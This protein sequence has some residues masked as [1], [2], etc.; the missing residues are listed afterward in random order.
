MPGF[1]SDCQKSVPFTGH[2]LLQPLMPKHQ[3]SKH[4]IIVNSKF[5]S[6][7]LPLPKTKPP[8]YYQLQIKSLPIPTPPQDDATPH[9]SA[10][11]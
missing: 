4:Q 7:T 2:I 6:P 3:K 10:S 11:H 5:D 8:Y 9:T 1:Y